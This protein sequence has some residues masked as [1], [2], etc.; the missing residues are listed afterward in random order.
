MPT[1]VCV[2]EHRLT[3][4]DGR[5]LKSHTTVNKTNVFIHTAQPSQHNGEAR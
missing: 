2:G 3:Q 1:C 5:L 4:P